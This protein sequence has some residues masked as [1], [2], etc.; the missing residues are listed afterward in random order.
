MKGGKP[1]RFVECKTADTVVSPALLYLRRKF[2]AVEA[3]QVLAIRGVDRIAREGIRLVSADRFLAEGQVEG[4]TLQAVSLTESILDS[5]DYAPPYYLMGRLLFNSGEFERAI[6]YLSTAEYLGLPTEEIAGE[7][8]RLLGVSL[9]ATGRYDE[10][11]LIWSRIASDGD[12][13]S[14]KYALDFMERTAWGRKNRL[15]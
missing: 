14:R 5:P 1:T 6:P 3:V 2:P 15:K 7:N 13:E 8:L 11:A 10:S 9:F 12:P 4:G